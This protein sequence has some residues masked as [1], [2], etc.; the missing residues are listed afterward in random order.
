MV[1]AGELKRPVQGPRAGIERL[2]CGGHLHALEFWNGFGKI[3]RRGEAILLLRIRLLELVAQAQIQRQ[4]LTNLE[5][6]I[7]V[8][9]VETGGR[10]GDDQA[11]HGR[12]V[13]VPVAGTGA[14]GDHRAEQERSVGVA[15]H[16]LIRI[17]I[18]RVGDIAVEPEARIRLL[19]DAR[20][21]RT[22]RFEP[23]FQIVL[24]ALLRDLGVKSVA[25]RALVP[26][27]PA[28]SHI[29]PAS[30]VSADRHARGQHWNTGVGIQ[31]LV[32][33]L[34]RVE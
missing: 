3:E 27:S 18:R 26:G 22:Q 24:A 15:G 20:C 12:F 25:E 5:I 29:D 7:D 21:M 14:D 13:A 1:L 32:K 30:S 8:R 28:R 33:G 19:Q 16:G 31:R 23:G 4:I 6:V 11:R 2:Q 17:D 10:G 34:I 9:S